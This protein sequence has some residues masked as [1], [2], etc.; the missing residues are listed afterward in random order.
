MACSK[1]NGSLLFP[2][3]GFTSMN[4]L[5]LWT[6]LANFSYCT[7]IS[8]W[9]GIIGRKRTGQKQHRRNIAILPMTHSIQCDVSR[10]DSQQYLSDGRILCGNIPEF[11]YRLSRRA[12]T[13]GLSDLAGY[14]RLHIS[15]KEFRSSFSSFSNQS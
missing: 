2:E 15:P 8:H 3:N 14:F 4:N 5:K 9:Y 13:A 10:V 12:K 11:L 7:L 1:E 6:K